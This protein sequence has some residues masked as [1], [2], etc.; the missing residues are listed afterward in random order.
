MRQKP[1]GAPAGELTSLPGT[2]W[3]YGD[4]ASERE[5]WGR[6][7]GTWKARRKRKGRGNERRETLPSRKVLKV[8][9][10]VSL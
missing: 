10:C 4:K 7:K 8:G 5:W 1:F 3:I 9:A 2:S 6:K